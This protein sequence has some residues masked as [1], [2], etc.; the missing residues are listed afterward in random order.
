M[1][2]G[3]RLCGTS[4]LNQ[5]PVARLASMTWH[6]RGAACYGWVWSC[7]RFHSAVAALL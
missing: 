4:E 1:S 7:D 6:V 2:L 3:I 5:V